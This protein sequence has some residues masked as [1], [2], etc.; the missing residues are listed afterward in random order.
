[1]K[2]H[3]ERTIFYEQ[4][5]EHVDHQTP[6]AQKYFF[7]DFN[8]RFGQKRVGEEDFLAIFALGVRLGTKLM[9]QTVICF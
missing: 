4:L 8:A 2:P 9:S 7:A 1:M 6:S 3:L 5:E